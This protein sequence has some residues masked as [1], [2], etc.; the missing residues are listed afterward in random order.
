MIIVI[1]LFMALLILDIAAIRWG[2]DSRDG[3]DSPEWERRQQ[4]EAFI[5]SLS[6]RK[7]LSCVKR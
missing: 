3:I 2:T 5:W 7:M 4:W 1:V 6:L